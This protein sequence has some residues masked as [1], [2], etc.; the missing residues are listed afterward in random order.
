[1][2]TSITTTKPK[3]APK[4]AGAN[5]T[6]A[7][8]SIFV[9]KGRDKKGNKVESEITGGSAALVKAQLL[10]QGVIVTSVR[11]K[12]KPLFG[13]GGKAIKPIDIAV[14]SGASRRQN[15]DERTI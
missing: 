1:M 10:K 15:G 6:T 4:K 7:S 3:A 2:A 8:T 13:G 12:A 14:F 9:Y 5:K 11:K